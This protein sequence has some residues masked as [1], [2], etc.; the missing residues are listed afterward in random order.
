MRLT[1]GRLI[2]LILSAIAVFTLVTVGFATSWYGFTAV[3]VSA[4]QVRQC[5]RLFAAIQADEDGERQTMA[6]GVLGDFSVYSDGAK[7]G[8]RR[9]RQLQ[10]PDG[11]YPLHP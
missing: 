3:H 4:A 2:A 6:A 7:S 5:N 1:T 10:C 8:L 11:P 9:M